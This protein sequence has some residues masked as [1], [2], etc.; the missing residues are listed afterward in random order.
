MSWT[1]DVP[2]S[3][4]GPNEY[5]AGYNVETDTRGI[6]NILGDQTILNAI[7]GTPLHVTANYRANDVFWFIIGSVDGSGN[8]HWYAMDSAGLTEITPS[9]GLT[10]YYKGMPITS[11]WNG[12][13]LFINDSVSAPM[14]LLANSGQLQQYSQNSQTITVTGATGNGTTATLSFATQSST[15]YALGSQIT[16]SGIDPAGYNGTWTVTA[17]TVSSVSFLNSTTGTYVSGGTIIPVYQWNYNPAWKTVTA[18]FMRMF[19]APNVGSILIAGNLTTVDQSNTITQYPCTVQWSQA[20][21]LN[22]APTT[23]VPT[24]TNVANQLE[25]PLRGPA[26]DGFNLNG[27]FYVCSY[28]DTVVFS[29]ISY[30]STSA[31]IFGIKL[32]SKGRGLLNANCYAAGD[33]VVFGVDARDFWMFD[34][35]SFTGIGNQRVKNTFFANLNPNYV[36]LVFCI[37]NTEKYQI[38]YYYPSLASTGA[39]DSMISYR[40][41]LDAWNPPRTISNATMATESPIWTGNTYNNGSRTV[42]YCQ[43]TASTQL[44]QKDQ[45]YTLLGNAISS[46]FRRDNIQLNQNFS[47]QALLHRVYPEIVVYSGNANAAITVNVGGSNSTGQPATLLGNVPMT[48]E[49]NTPW[50]QFN[51]NAFRLNTIE[52]NTVTSDYQWEMTAVNWQFTPT[53]DQR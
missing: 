14:F 30:Q 23:W 37:N 27:N 42:V 9:S 50:T 52:V 21:G 18:G 24:I 34:G 19:S 44:V 22:Q 48:I 49:T 46:Q 16:V 10:G 12:N 43:G 29:P 11:S 3:A 26:L 47:Q 45:G 2:A 38:E 36:D 51:Q 17:C 33:G 31:P 20:F 25:I 15:P 32:M 13:V 35:N 41:D 4:L 53:Q 39:C 5:N 40:Y 8:G 7:S 1:P 6:K 28:W